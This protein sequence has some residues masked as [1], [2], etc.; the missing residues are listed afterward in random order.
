[1]VGS[2]GSGKEILEGMNAKA[3]VAKAAEMI[4]GCKSCIDI[5]AD[6]AKQREAYGKPIGGFQII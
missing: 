4:G 2:L 6:R 1:M 3:A 5:T